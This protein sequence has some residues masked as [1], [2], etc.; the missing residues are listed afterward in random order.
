MEAF[1][2]RLSWKLLLI[3]GPLAL[4]IIVPGIYLI[5]QGVGK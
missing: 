4:T 2:D 5:W 3:A 1:L